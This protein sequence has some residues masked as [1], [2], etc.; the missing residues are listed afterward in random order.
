MRKVGGDLKGRIAFFEAKFDMTVPI[1]IGEPLIPSLPSLSTLFEKKA[2][3][4]QWSKTKFLV[5]SSR[6]ERNSSWKVFL[7]AGIKRDLW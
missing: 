4:V 6:M 1:A 5:I 3:E 7:G 2:A